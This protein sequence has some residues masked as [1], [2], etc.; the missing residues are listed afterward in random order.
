MG[1]TIFL[2]VII[3]LF[4]ISVAPQIRSPLTLTNA[5]FLNKIN[6]MILKDNL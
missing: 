6:E 5:T 1:T 2:P 3:V 4:D